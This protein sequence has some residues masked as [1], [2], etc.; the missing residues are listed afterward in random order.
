MVD[1]C[2]AMTGEPTADVERKMKL[3]NSVIGPGVDCGDIPFFNTVQS[4]PIRRATSILSCEASGYLSCTSESRPTVIT[5]RLGLLL[6]AYHRI[7]P[8]LR[9][10]YQT[11][12]EQSPVA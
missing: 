2:L 5:I 3:S 12:T 6:H 11:S 10:D 7:V 4:A 9:W 1:I 8:C